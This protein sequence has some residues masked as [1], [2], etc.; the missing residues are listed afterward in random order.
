MFLRAKDWLSKHLWA[1]SA[2]YF[3]FYLLTF[4]VL[5]QVAV[6]KYII[7]AP[8]DDLIPFCEWFIFPYFAWF[9]LIAWSLLYFLFHSREDYLRLCFL[10]YVGMTVCLFIYAVAPNG[11]ELRVELTRDNWASRLVG[12]LQSMDTPTNVC[13]SIHVLVTAVINMVVLHS[14]ALKGK[15]GLKTG[16]T[17]LAVLI[18]LS[19]VF[20]KQHSVIDVFWGLVLAFVLR[21]VQ[22]LWEKR[23]KRI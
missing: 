10:M 5:E 12:A 23:K 21:G 4:F 8:L 11:L 6:P 19:T 13:P 9:A 14:R 3:L 17:A 15:V 18:C 20:L 1:I 7:H 2:V 16:V 22:L